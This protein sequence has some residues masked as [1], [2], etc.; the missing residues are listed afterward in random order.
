MQRFSKE[1]VLLVS[2]LI[3]LIICA[4]TL[5]MTTNTITNVSAVEANGVGVYWD[6]T[7]TNGVS[8]INW[9]TITPGSRVKVNVYIRNEG[10]SSETFFMNTANW[11]PS[12]AHEY[13]ILSWN[14]RGQSIGSGKSILV[15]LI[16]S[17]SS[18]IRGITN[19]NFDIIIGIGI[20][21]APDLNGDGIVDSMDILIVAIA[22]GSKPGDPNWDIRADLFPQGSG[23]GVID[24]LDILQV[25][26]HFGEA[27]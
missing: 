9:G 10:N 12:N 5:L 13:M 7:C 26:L 2:L 27:G 3:S 17:V 4:F 18:S 15:T 8:S 22:F 21:K 24:S 6:S 19:F 1:K 11:N 14:Y 23:D 16:L 25:G 20:N